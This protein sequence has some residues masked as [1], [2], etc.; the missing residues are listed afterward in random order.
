MGV[1]VVNSK[2]YFSFDTVDGNPSGTTCMCVKPC[3]YIHLFNLYF[4]CMYSIGLWWVLL[5]SIQK[6]IFLLILLMETLVEPHV[7][8]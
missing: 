3:G 5:W 2:N 6:I 7:C 8:V 4:R 1:V